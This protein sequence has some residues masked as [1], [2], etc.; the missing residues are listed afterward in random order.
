MNVEKDDMQPS[1][2]VHFADVAKDFSAWHGLKQV[3]H[4]MQKIQKSRKNDKK[5]VTITSW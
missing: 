3:V 4:W 5:N 2:E 1:R